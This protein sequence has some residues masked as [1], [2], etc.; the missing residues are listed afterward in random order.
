MIMSSLKS[1]RLKNGI[2]AESCRYSSF[3]HFLPL[4]TSRYFLRIFFSFGLKYFSGKRKGLGLAKKR[5]ALDYDIGASGN[6]K[7]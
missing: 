1:N 5:T 6:R 3:L 2:L 4:R 7:K